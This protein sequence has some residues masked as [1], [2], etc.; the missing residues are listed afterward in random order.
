VGI[1]EMLSNFEQMGKQAETLWLIQAAI[2][3]S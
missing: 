1:D 2:W 3:P